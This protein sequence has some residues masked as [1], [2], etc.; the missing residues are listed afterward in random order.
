MRLVR[1]L[2]LEGSALE[3][4]R[5]FLAAYALYLLLDGAEEEQLLLLLLFRTACRIRQRVYQAFSYSSMRP[6]TT[7]VC[8]LKL[9]VYE[10]L[11]Y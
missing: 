3:C 7:S 6:Y 8:G 5:L 4:E 2:V 9:L 11:S 10:A 1:E